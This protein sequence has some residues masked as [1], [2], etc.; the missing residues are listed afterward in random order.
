MFK[1]NLFKNNKYRSIFL[2]VFSLI[3]GNL[4]IAIGSNMFLISARIF[5]TGVVG[6]SDEVSRIIEIST[7][8]V[9]P[10]NYIFLLFNIPMIIF[11]Y[12]KIGKR[13]IMK[14]LVSVV[15]FTIF[16][17]LVP[18][19]SPI[20]GPNSTTGDFL[21]SAVVA[22]IIWGT[23]IGLL[24]KSGASSGGTDIIAVYVS[25][26]RGKSFGI[27]NLVMNS[28]VIVIAYLITHNFIS[29]ILSLITL[30]I[31]NIVIDKIHN[32][33]EKRVL[34]IITKEMEEV[35][36]ALY[37]EL[38][39]GITILNSVGGYSK[40]PNNTLL[41]SISEGELLQAINTIKQTDGGA[42]I[43]VIKAESVIG[44]FENPYQKI[45]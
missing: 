28:V 4:L 32:S 24:L 31:T 2:L 20:V 35:T 27:Y 37:Q 15:L 43:N 14:S 3:V 10:Y 7:G 12:F 18:T 41:I 8:M 9:I 23:G 6:L 26:Y 45:L 40:D 36:T 25:I 44:N 5:P 38:F 13:F 19:V 11:G 21:L 22:A 42:F 16:S 17:N 30:Y 1:Y 29:T 34:I 33:Q 39:R